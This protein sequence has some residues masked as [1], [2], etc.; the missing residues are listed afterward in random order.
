MTTVSRCVSD[1]FKRRRRIRRLAVRHAQCQSLELCKLVFGPRSLLLDELPTH[2][3]AVEVC[4]EFPPFP[5]P[6]VLKPLDVLEDINLSSDEVPGV[7]CVTL[8]LN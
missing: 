2:A 6:V 4:D 8:K 5:A 1:S 7:A 3:F